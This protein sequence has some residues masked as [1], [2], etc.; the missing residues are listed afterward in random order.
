[1]DDVTHLLL[2]GALVVVGVV[3]AAL[4]DRIRGVR[5]TRESLPRAAATTRSKPLT[6]RHTSIAVN[7]AAQEDVIGALVT[8]G[9]PKRAAAAATAR[10]AP[11]QRTTPEAWTRAALT[12]LR[13]GGGLP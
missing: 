1:M 6:P 8:A 9:F 10:C 13:P 2:G 5:S 3:A 4:A 12:A 11:E 7:N